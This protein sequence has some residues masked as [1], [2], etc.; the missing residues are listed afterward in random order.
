[1]LLAA[2]LAWQRPHK[3]D[4]ECQLQ[5]IV[6]RFV[7]APF[8]G[9]LE[10]SLVK[11]GDVVAEGD[12]LAQ[13]DGRETRLELS[14]LEAEFAQARKAWEVSLSIDDIHEAQQAKLEMKRLEL[15]IE[16]LRQQQQD[17]QIRSPL[18]GF[19]VSG[20]LED[21]EG[22]P[23]KVG[24]SLFEIAPTERM[25]VEVVIPEAEIAY[26]RAGMETRIRLDA[27]PRQ[28]LSAK[29]THIVPR[30]EARDDAFVFVAEAELDNAGEL[31]RPGMNGRATLIGNRRPLAWL[32][33][34]KPCES[35]LML[36]GW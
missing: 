4:C 11:P 15:K 2:L 3:I 6:R 8:D 13:M 7:A 31:L 16:I 12:V 14:A 29:L 33:F 27:Y 32:L 18:R 28:P 19:V 20:D 10:E 36:L 1:M 25:K 30:A 23:L 22:A 35:L 26:V 9:T 34:H 5:P 24:Q 17:L 21:C